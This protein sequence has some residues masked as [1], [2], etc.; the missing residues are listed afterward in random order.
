MAIDEQAQ[1]NLDTLLPGHY[2]SANRFRDYVN[3]AGLD[4][5][6]RELVT[7][8]M[9]VALGGC[10]PQVKDTPLPTCMSAKTGRTARRTHPSPTIHRPPAL[11]NGLKHST[12]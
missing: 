3:C 5:R 9:L 12:P 4:V 8:A 6:T 1:R 7:F 10:G 11:P 2:L